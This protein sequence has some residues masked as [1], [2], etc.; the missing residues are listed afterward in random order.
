MISSLSLEAL[1]QILDVIPVRVFWKDRDSRFLGCNRLFAEDAGITDP[2]EFVGKSD[3]YFYHPEQAHAFRLDDA[4]V[5]FSGNPKLGIIEK[6][7]R[8]DGSVVWLETNKLP[9]RDGTG[10][11][12]GV[13]GMYFDIS[14]R[15]AAED[16]RCR[17]CLSLMSEFAAA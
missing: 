11:V 16:E 12:I 14:E 8:D 1:T 9:M 5:M 3:F 7:V 2:Q 13:I 6:I 15:K 4:E 10:A 17:A